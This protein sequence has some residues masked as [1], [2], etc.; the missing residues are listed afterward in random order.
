MKP[1]ENAG[2]SC[3][4]ASTSELIRKGIGSTEWAG[5]GFLRWAWRMLTGGELGWKLEVRGSDF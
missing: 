3:G 2:L 5:V 4:G 1:F